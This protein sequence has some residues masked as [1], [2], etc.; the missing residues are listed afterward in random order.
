MKPY[1]SL[2]EIFDKAYVGLAKQN[3]RR[4]ITITAGG[5]VACAYRGENGTKCAIGHVV[6]DEMVTADIGTKSLYRI[7][8]GYTHDDPSGQQEKHFP[9][10]NEL[11]KNIPL[12]A[13]C[14]LQACHDNARLPT[15]YA[16]ITDLD[17]P[18][19]MKRQLESFAKRYELTIPVLEAA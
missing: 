3:W 7:L 17:N 4:A 1:E 6:P 16:D 9:E 8:T 18:K 12:S 14:S 11:F 10:W 2:Q 19:H 15:N 5:Q 13:L